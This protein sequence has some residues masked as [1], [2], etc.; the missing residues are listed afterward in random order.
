MMKKNHAIHW[1]W[2]H[3]DSTEI[4]HQFKLFYEENKNEW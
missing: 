4:D 3:S 2:S 1:W